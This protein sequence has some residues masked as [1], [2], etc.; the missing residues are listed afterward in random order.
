[1]R[2]QVFLMRISG[3]RQTDPGLGLS[4]CKRIAIL[5]GFDLTLCNRTDGVSGLKV[6]L[7]F[8]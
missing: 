1:M 4:I 6:S 2:V 5:N 8:R 3:N 7:F